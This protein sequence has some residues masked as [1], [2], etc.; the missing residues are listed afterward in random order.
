MN[1]NIFRATT[2][3]PVERKR[4]I[5]SSSLFRERKDI[6]LVHGEEE[7]VLRITRNGKLILTK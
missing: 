2:D 1:E 6:V 4:R 7:Y 3:Q 5:N